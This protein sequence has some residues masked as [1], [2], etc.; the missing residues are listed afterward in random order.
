MLTLPVL[1]GALVQRAPGRAAPEGRDHRP[2]PGWRPVS[3]LSFHL[4]YCSLYCVLFFC[5]HG[6]SDPGLLH[7]GQISWGLSCW[8]KTP[9]LSSQ[10]AGGISGGASSGGASGAL[11]VP[12]KSFWG[13]SIGAPWCWR[14]SSRGWGGRCPSQRVWTTRLPRGG[15]VLRAQGLAV[16]AIH[17]V[18][19][20]ISAVSSPGGLDRPPLRPRQLPPEQTALPEGIPLRSWAGAGQA[21]PTLSWLL[22]ESG[23][24]HDFVD[25]GWALMP[26]PAG[27]ALR[28]GAL[29]FPL[30]R[31]D[32]ASPLGPACGGQEPSVPERTA[33]LCPDSPTAGPSGSGFK[34]CRSR[35][36]LASLPLSR[37]VLC[38]E[39]E[40]GGGLAG[41][42]PLCPGSGVS[43]T[44][45]L[46]AL[47]TRF[48]IG[49]CPKGGFLP[50]LLGPLLWHLSSR[51]C[52][53]SRQ[54][55]TSCPVWCSQALPPRWREAWVGA[56][57]GLTHGNSQARGGSTSSHRVRG[58][59]GPYGWVGGCEEARGGPGCQHSAEN[60]G[61]PS[62]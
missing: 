17:P 14:V 22:P 49:L 58:K 43:H 30:Q 48:P 25:L 10:H 16:A 61:R 54:G 32:L 31:Q 42:L 28:R 26:C 46:L 24:G 50:P 37:W 15:D 11:Q 8:Q 12:G 29:G 20:L 3:R 36:S 52:C 45:A 34:C 47:H 59:P 44:R 56:P 62:L 6:L 1:L 39:V 4:C 51:L 55:V 19:L 41:G 27:P 57:A 40:R 13:Q 2:L 23:P 60:S 18:L 21:P 9:P 38:F 33:Q 5:P 53:E 7:R 35:G